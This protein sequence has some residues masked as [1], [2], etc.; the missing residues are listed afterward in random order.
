MI[1]Y[2]LK[3][4]AQEVSYILNTLSEKPYREVNQ[5]I[6]KVHKAASEQTAEYEKA[7]KNG[8]SDKRE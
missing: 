2:I 7:Q 4:N 6:G 8:N 1:E 5:L 3:L